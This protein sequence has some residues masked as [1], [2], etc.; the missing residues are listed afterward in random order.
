VRFFLG[1]NAVHW[2]SDPRSAEA[3]LF[4]SRRRLSS[5]KTLPPAAGSFAL[6]SGGFTELQ[7]HGKWT[8]TA[9]QYA[10]EVGRF[11]R[12]YEEKLL[13]VAPQDWMCEPIVI[14][15]GNAG[16]GV[17]F[18]G[19]RSYVVEHQRR[20]VKNFVALRA[21]LGDLV[22]PV[23]QGWSLVDYRRCQELYAKA[24][25]RLADE[26]TVGLGSVCRRQSTVEA[27]EIVTALA[28]DGL[29]LHG[30][31]FKK[32]GVKN[33]H[34]MLASADSM[35]WSATARQTP[36]LLPDHDKPGPGRCGGHK[37]C[38]SCAEWAFMWREQLMREIETVEAA[39]AFC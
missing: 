6:D 22:I 15:G 16:R 24:G 5:Y 37:N 19:T 13:W 36:V 14:T 28:A 9:E 8:I 1:T 17:V 31:G 32:G 23:L 20:T 38:T 39:P 21:L 18:R 12:F 33:C 35:A 34:K 26:P 30:F 27:T 7:M 29:R 25:V 4:V 3:P 2:L 11:V 10:E